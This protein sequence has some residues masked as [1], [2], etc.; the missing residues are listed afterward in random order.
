MSSC[1]IAL[2]MVI[3]FLLLLLGIGI[4][5][6]RISTSFRE[7]VLGNQELHT[8]PLV[9]TLL[10]LIYGGGRLMIGVEQIHNFGLSWVFF[11]LATSVFPYWLISWLSLR[12]RPFMHN[13]SMSESI[14]R[15]YGKY[16]RMV[17]GLA[18]IGLAIFTISIQIN[19]MSRSISMC[20][21][22]VDRRIITICAILILVFYARI[23]GLRIITF[24]DVAQIF[25]FFIIIPFLAFSIFEAT[26]K[27][28]MLS[29]LRTKEM[30]AFDKL[31][32]CEPKQLAVFALF[33]SSLVVN[34]NPPVIQKIYMSA[35]CLQAGMVFFFTSIFSLFISVFII[36]IGLYSLIAAP[37][38]LATE[39]WIY[40]MA[41]IA[42]IFKGFVVISLLT[43]AIS[44]ADTYLNS[45]CVM[46]SNDIV[47]SMMTK[48]PVSYNRQLR[49]A[50]VTALFVGVITII[51]S[52][53]CSDLF[54]L[55]KFR[56][57]C[58][59]PIVTAPFILA[60]LG[61][62]G[63]SPTAL[64]G[65]ATGLLTILSWNKWIEPATTINGSCMAMIANGM[66]MMAAHYLLPK[67]KK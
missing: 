44:T 33:L 61:F 18:N 31:W 30:F 62:R 60:I 1:N 25:V 3:V 7:Y 57:D 51:V 32:Q 12:M 8:P 56:F 48:K 35:D 29:L 36:L 22:S 64:I 21:D 54:S 39:V 67:Q 53:S 37:H 38:L 14:G 59:I 26:G 43:M 42:P 50:K 15:V 63:S 17:T 6:T 34:I 20:I 5:F 41:H 40:I 9:G 52:F 47:S 45:C 24:T 19:V 2:T 58:F 23:G 55:F 13:L 10:A 28:K 16:P 27:P 65:M 11:I 4:F 49:L 66:A 46:F